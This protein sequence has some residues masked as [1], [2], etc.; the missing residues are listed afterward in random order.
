MTVT[1]TYAN[2]GDVG[3]VRLDVTVGGL[4][5]WGPSDSA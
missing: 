5:S 2:T 3:V 4:N 1:N